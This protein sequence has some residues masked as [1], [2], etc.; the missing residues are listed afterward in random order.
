M[1]RNRYGAWEGGPDPLAPPYDVRAAV[2]AVG[3]DVLAGRGLR[4][5]LRD[6]LRRGMNG[7]AGLDALQSRARRMRWSRQASTKYSH[8]RSA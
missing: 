3:R 7:R 6:L 2:D 1:N 8:R 5:A 4:E